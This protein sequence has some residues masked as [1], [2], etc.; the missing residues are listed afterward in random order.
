MSNTQPQP[1]NRSP[2]PEVK[3]ENLPLWIDPQLLRIARD[4]YQ[5]YLKTH[6]K[7]PQRPLGVT[8]NP[9][10]YQAKL[11]FLRKPVLLPME[12]FIPFLYIETQPA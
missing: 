7:Q 4:L 6:V 12:Q 10:T 11:I 3:A 5:A 8:V 9:R 2:E 1:T